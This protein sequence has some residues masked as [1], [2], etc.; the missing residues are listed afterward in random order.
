MKAHITLSDSETI[1]I[2]SISPHPANARR[3]DVDAIAESLNYHGQYK[4]IVVNKRTNEILAGNHTY[5]AAKRLKWGKIAVVW[6]DVDETTARKIL[7][8][9][10]RTND[11]AH[12]DETALINLIS[13]LPDLEG[14]GF[15]AEE[16]ND[17]DNLLSGPL[18]APPSSFP[19]D[20]D[21]QA[22]VLGPHRGRI[23]PDQ[24][25]TWSSQLE[26]EHDSKKPRIIN[27]IR[28]RL[29]IP[30]PTPLKREDPE[31]R[32]I[33]PTTINAQT[34]PITQLKTYPGNARTGD[35]G[36]ISESLHTLGQYRPIIANSNGYIL[37]GN[38]TYQA[39]KL[40]GWK[41]IAVTYIDVD[42][43]QAAKIVLIDNRTADKATYDT[44]NL[45]KL[46]ASIPD[47]VG[48]GYGPDDAHEILTGGPTRPGPDLSGKTT[49][50]IGEYAFR[51]PRHEIDKWAKPLT[52]EIIADRLGFTQGSITE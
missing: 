40:L 39:A 9:D 47:Y 30:T 41:E 52:L 23:D 14:S 10:N 17:L 36:A 51:A 5:K 12:Y 29:Q 24:Y 2:N 49:C 32:N 26:D 16:L 34:V 31:T 43:T 13:E 18:S 7:L 20:N 35:I 3:G 25:E 38:H 27:A 37:A 50:R 21:E 8:A 6:V 22:L 33:P 45:K 19:P 48:T 4:P 15:T 42:E 46:I 11:L 44:D 1:P 28:E